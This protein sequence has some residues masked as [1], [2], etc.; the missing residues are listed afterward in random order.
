MSSNVSGG[1]KQNYNLPDKTLG[2]FNDGSLGMHQI[3]ER[4]QKKSK[5]NNNMF[6]LENNSCMGLSHD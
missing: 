3:M 4:K 1:I 6:C 5:S 2:V